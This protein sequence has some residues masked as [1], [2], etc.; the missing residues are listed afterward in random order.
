[1]PTLHNWCNTHLLNS[2]PQ[3]LIL[4]R[5]TLRRALANGEPAEDALSSLIRALEETGTRE[6]TTDL[7]E[8]LEQPA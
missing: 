6:W 4:S 7:A 5:K 8:T 2:S 1:M 3:T